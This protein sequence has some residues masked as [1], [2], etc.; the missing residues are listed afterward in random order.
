MQQALPETPS[1]IWPTPNWRDGAA[2]GD[3]LALQHL[4]RRHNQTL[5]RTARNINMRLGDRL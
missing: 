5:Y 2:S 4:M 3:M 1:R